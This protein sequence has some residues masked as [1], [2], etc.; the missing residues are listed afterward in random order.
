ML[1]PADYTAAKAGLMALHA[2]VK[3]ELPPD[4]NIKTLLVTPGQMT[5]SLF[6]GVSTPSAFFAPVLE[7]V[8][9][10]KEIIG[11]IDSG[12][13]G[14]LAMPLYA[15]WIQVLG[16]LPVS[17]QRLLRAVSGVDRGMQSFIGRSKEF[18]EG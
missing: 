11:A 1:D 12:T 9:V 13:S 15:R 3:A 8:D 4:A 6:A 14:E 10:A 18:V 5:T 16:I 2:S 17:V 7:P